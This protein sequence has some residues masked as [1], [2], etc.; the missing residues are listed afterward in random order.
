MSTE[1]RRIDLW[2]DETSDC[3]N[4]VWCVSLCTADGEEIK[5]LDTAASHAD[6]LPVAEK[7]A[8]SHG[9]VLMDCVDQ[10]SRIARRDESVRVRPTGPPRD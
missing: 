9:L 6:A 2:Y 8:A 7:K 4:P 1:N 3:E 10:T 5:V